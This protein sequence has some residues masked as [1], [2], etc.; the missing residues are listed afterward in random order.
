MKNTMKM[1]CS[2]AV[3]AFLSTLIGSQTVFAGTLAGYLDSKNQRRITSQAWNTHG[4]Y[5]ETTSLVTAFSISNDEKTLTPGDGTDAK[6]Q[7]AELNTDASSTTET[8]KKDPSQYGPGVPKP[9]E[10]VVKEE[11]IIEEV[12][13]SVPTQGTSLGIFTTTGYCSCSKCSG[14]NNLTYSGTIPKANHTISADI[15]VLPIGTKVMINGVVYTVEDIG[16]SVH[17]NKIDIYYASHDAAWAH[18]RQ[19]VEVFSVN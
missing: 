2:M 1:I 5:E 7:A 17:G 8:Q 15:T 10:S 13:E 4:F 18:G 6:P 14:G 9:Q 16:G 3:F 12:T 11:T 19:K